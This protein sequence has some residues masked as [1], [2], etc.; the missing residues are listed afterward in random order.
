[1]TPVNY[2]RTTPPENATAIVV[3]CRDHTGT[4]FIREQA[5]GKDVASIG[6]EEDGHLVI[7]PWKHG[8][9]YFSIGWIRLAYIPRKMRGLTAAGDTLYSL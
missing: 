9:F 5:G 4:I 6:T 1:L 7:V 3:D 2:V 8:W